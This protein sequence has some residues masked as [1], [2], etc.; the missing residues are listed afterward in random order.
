MDGN[1]GVGGGS[2]TA[3][4]GPNG[5]GKTTLLNRVTGLF[6]A[7]EGRIEICDHDIATAPRAPPLA[8]TPP[9]GRSHDRRRRNRRCQSRRCTGRR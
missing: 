8:S 7:A 3:L 5:A 9:T 2:V 4:L 1:L 6:P